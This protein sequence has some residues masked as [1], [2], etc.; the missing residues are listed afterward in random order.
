MLLIWGV[1]SLA[2]FSL[3]AVYAPTDP[4]GA[5]IPQS[6]QVLALAAAILFLAGVGGLD[7]I[8]R[9][10]R[11]G[12]SSGAPH[13]EA[14]TALVEGLRADAGWRGEVTQALSTLLDTTAELSRSLQEARGA[15]L[16]DAQQ[17]RHNVE[18]PA[19]NAVREL[20]RRTE[21]I[22]FMVHGF[23]EHVKD[24]EQ[25]AKDAEAIRA[26]TSFLV[27]RAGGNPS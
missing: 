3:G 11:A 8:K 14:V 15:V 20:V 6:V 4:S 16:A 12:G 5:M 13:A 10:R 26:H 19:L 21:G 17:T 7:V 22:D 24:V 9:I 2:S 23:D 18:V 25:V 1:S 27:T